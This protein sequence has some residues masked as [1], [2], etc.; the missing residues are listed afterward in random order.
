M[1]AYSGALDQEEKSM[2]ELRKVQSGMKCE[3]LRWGRWHREMNRDQIMEDSAYYG[4]GLWK[5]SAVNVPQ[6]QLD[7]YFTKLSASK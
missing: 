6:A 2:E 1:I 5:Q 7:L 4:K 3:W